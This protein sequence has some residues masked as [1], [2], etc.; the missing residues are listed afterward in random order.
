MTLT[1]IYDQGMAP[2]ATPARIHHFNTYV[3]LHHTRILIFRFEQNIK[4]TQR[5]HNTVH[6][7]LSV[8]V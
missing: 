2:Y 8:S 5:I 1:A 7:L 4:V 3:R 6:W